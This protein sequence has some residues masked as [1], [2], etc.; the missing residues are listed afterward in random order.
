MI[1]EAISEYRTVLETNPDC[2]E[3]HSNLAIAYYAK[4]SFDL[5]LK[6]VEIAAKLKVPPHPQFIELLKEASQI[7]HEDRP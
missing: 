3:A 1:D 5:A 6:H 2:A 4:G 7:D